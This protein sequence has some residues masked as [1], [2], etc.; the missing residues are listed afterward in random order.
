MT[1]HSKYFSPELLA[2]KTVLITG[3]GT[4]LGLAMGMKF[5]TLGANVVICGRRSEVLDTAASQLREAGSGFVETHQCDIRSSEEVEA[6]MQSISE[7][8]PIDI[9][10]NNA[11][12]NFIAQRVLSQT[13][14]R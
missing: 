7:K 14:R 5:M 1:Q 11:A 12:A 9:L 2:G 3:G 4:G 13:S 8:T 6:M 10:V